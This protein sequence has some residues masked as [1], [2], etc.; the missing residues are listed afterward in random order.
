MLVLCA[1]EQPVACGRD[2]GALSRSESNGAAE[3]RLN[4]AQDVIEAP[5]Q[6]PVLREAAI[7]ATR[8]STISN[9]DRRGYLSSSLWLPSFY[10]LTEAR[11]PL[12][13]RPLPTV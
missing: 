12:Q 13:C 3:Q 11:D 8:V 10:G 9:F 4:T 5:R 2:A 6:P 1:V 7:I